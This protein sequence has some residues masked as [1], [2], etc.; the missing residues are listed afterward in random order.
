M[1]EAHTLLDQGRGPWEGVLAC[2]PTEELQE[3]TDAK[4]DAR[5]GVMGQ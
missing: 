2:R 4:R 3:K 5:C 1:G